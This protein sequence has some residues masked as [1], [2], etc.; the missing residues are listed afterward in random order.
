[1]QRNPQSHTSFETR[2]IQK[3]HLPAKEQRL[4]S[5]LAVLVK[6]P[7]VGKPRHR[8]VAQHQR[9]P[10][11]LGGLGERWPPSDR[12]GSAWPAAETCKEALKAQHVPFAKRIRGSCVLSQHT[13]I[14]AH[15]YSKQSS[16]ASIQT[17]RR[18]AA[19]HTLAAWKPTSDVANQRSS[20]CCMGFRGSLMNCGCLLTNGACLGGDAYRI[21]DAGRDC[22]WPPAHSHCVQTSSTQ[23]HRAVRHLRPAKHLKLQKRSTLKLV[24]R[25]SC[26]SSLALGAGWRP[27]GSW[28]IAMNRPGA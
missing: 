2:E 5:L 13:G 6:I 10:G 19:G 8:L 28:L 1:M 16:D 27:Y 20:S 14:P 7:Q 17:R 15:R 12:M 21:G 25:Q 4:D 26:N 11:L 18:A 23:R 22:T 3:F 24:L 9:N